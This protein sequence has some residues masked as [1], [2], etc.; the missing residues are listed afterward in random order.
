MT[1]I[2]LLSE[3]VRVYDSTTSGVSTLTTRFEAMLK[4]GRGNKTYYSGRLLCRSQSETITGIETGAQAVSGS[5]SVAG[6]IGCKYL[7]LCQRHRLQRYHYH[8]SL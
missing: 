5:S 1:A 8:V 7:Q 2:T 3:T 6:V 4:A